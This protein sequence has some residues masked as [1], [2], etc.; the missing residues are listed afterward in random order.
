MAEPISQLQGRRL[1][2]EFFNGLV[3]PDA[4]GLLLR[5][6]GDP[7]A[8]KQRRS[9]AEWKAFC[10]QCK[11]DFRFDPVKEGPLKAAQLLADRGNPWSKVWQRFA[12][13]PANYPGI[14]EWLKRAAPKDSSMFDSAEV[15][16][17]INENEERKLQQALESLVDRPQDEVIGRGGCCTQE[18][19]GRILGRRL[20]AIEPILMRAAMTQTLSRYIVADPQ[21]CHGQPTFRG[22]RIFVADVLEQVASG[23]AWDTIVEEWRGDITKEAIAEAVRLAR[24]SLLEHTDELVMEPVTAQLQPYST[25]WRSTR[26]SPVDFGFVSMMLVRF[27]RHERR[28]M[29][30]TP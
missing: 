15:W 16:P 17:N 10:E 9:D 26:A 22:T 7:E 29:S 5:W 2:A 8:F 24:E 23:M 3:A 13:A 19:W 4:T 12:E 14:V 21:I 20:H 18:G 25:S 30:A 28:A 6:L 1:D 11:A 27:R